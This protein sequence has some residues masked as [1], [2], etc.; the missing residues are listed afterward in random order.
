M[1]SSE[2]KILL[3]NE[4]QIYKLFIDGDL[5]DLVIIYEKYS[6]LFGLV[7]FYE[8]LLKSV[9]YDIDVLMMIYYDEDVILYL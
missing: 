9:M 4:E 8:K 2:E 3:S 5:N 7:D 1:Y 6:R